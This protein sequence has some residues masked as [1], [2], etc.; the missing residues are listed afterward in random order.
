MWLEVLSRL[1]NPV[2]SSGIEHATFRLVAYYLNH[3]RYRMP[4]SIPKIYVV[5]A[6]SLSFPAP[7]H[8][9][10]SAFISGFCSVHYITILPYSSV[11]FTASLHGRR[12]DALKK[13]SIS[14]SVSFKA[15][16]LL[17]LQGGIIHGKKLVH[18]S[19]PKKY[20]SDFSRD[21]SALYVYRQGEIIQLLKCF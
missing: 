21:R 11:L 16:I 15:A 20:F 7:I 10:I 6:E 19:V 2:T 17:L 3:E 13:F 14:C 12:I 18:C 1:K 5:T 4:L 9:D 8:V